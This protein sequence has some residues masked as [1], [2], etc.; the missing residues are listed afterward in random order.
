MNILHMKYAVEVANVGSINKASETLLIAQPNLSRAIKELE[1]DLGITIFDRSARG[2]V[3]THDGEIFI[4]YARQILKQIQEVENLYRGGTAKKKHFSVSV[5]RAS[6]ISEAFARFS[7]QIGTGP[8]EIFYQETN[9]QRVIDNILHSDYHLGII[10][11]AVQHDHY[12]K[13]LLDE[14]H[15]N[16]ELITEFHYVLIMHE[17]H[18]LAKR[19]AVRF[20]D[21]DQYIEIAHADPYVPSLSLA[22]ARKAELPDNAERRIYIFD[23]ASQFDLLS[24]N[25]ETYMWVSPLPAKLLRRYSLV[26]REC[27][28]NQRRYK[29]VL[30]HRDNYRLSALDRSFIT[31]VCQTK[32]R[33]M[34]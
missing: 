27:T 17:D 26:Q 7:N 13:E 6:Y 4:G 3:L 18:P 33:Y 29:D 1:A 9:A 16:Y 12:F 24:E 8:V 21:L 20:A 14:K 23:R 11:Y 2:M 30:I 10:R 5:P 28:D 15:L 22:E 19:D 32:R 31:E 34:S 25:K